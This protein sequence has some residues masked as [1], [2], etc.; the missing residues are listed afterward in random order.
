[1]QPSLSIH[2]ELCFETSGEP[3]AKVTAIVVAAGSATRMG[4]D[5]QMIPLLGVPALIRSL[6]AFDLCPDIQH[7]V[8]VAKESALSEVR[9]LCKRYE[10]AKLACVV[11]G[12]ST[13]QESVLRGLE[14]CPEETEYYAIH[15]GARP[16]VTEKCIRQAI[17]GAI[18]H[19][20][21]APG[22]QV[23]DTL[24]RI[25][26]D[27]RVLKT[28]EREGLI[29]VQTPQVFR[30]QLYQEAVRRSQGQNWQVTDDCALCERA[31]FEVYITEGCYSNI[32]ITTVEDVAMA[33]ALLR[34]A[35][36]SHSAL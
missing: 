6:Y 13:R 14:A 18:R 5:K 30:R 20:A 11:A 24:K 15:D 2:P 16:L 34:Q 29:A 22:M 23:K 35:E 7:I 10:I 3:S 1:M 25:D 31:G 26:K 28:P 27:G 21:A 32:K 9:Q 33:E 19:G 12:G 17:R 8:V 36:P 4:R